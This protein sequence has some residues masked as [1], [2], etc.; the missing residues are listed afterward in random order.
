MNR[1]D[2]SRWQSFTIGNLF[3]VKKGTRLVKAAMKEGDYPFIGASAVNNGI[4]A[5]ISNNEHIHRG[6]TI[7]LSYNGSVGEAFYQDCEFWASDDVNVLYP[8][9][10]MNRYIAMYIIPVLKKAGQKYRFI[11]KWK[12]DD[13]EKDKIKLP[14][15]GTGKPD[16]AFMEE[17]MKGLDASLNA[18]LKKIQAT[19]QPWKTPPATA[20]HWGK[21]KI[22]ELFHTEN[23]GKKLRVPTGASVKRAELTDGEIPRITVTGANNG[24]FGFFDCKNNNPNYRIYENFISVSFLGTVFYQPSEASL[25]MKVHCLKLRDGEL[26]KYTGQYLVTCIKKSLKE[27]RYSDQISSTVLP[28]LDIHLPVDGTGKPD[29][30]FMEEYMKEKEASVCASLKQLQKTMR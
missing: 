7:T 9:F 18:A 6:N 11:D 23:I 3:E 13:M 16:F 14:V 10:E 29:F 26:N 2:T 12:K 8:K 4:T 15:D 24:I 17:Y 27:S 30:A 21:F 5:R 1:I 28:K 19:E 25:D 22:H 20:L